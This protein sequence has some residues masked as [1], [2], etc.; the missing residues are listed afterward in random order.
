MLIDLQLPGG[1][2]L[3]RAP[4][5]NLKQRCLSVICTGERFL[6]FGAA[7]LPLTSRS[8]KVD[9]EKAEKLAKNVASIAPSR[10]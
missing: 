6:V 1:H 9:F 5:A 7:T 8:N 10:D 3:F 2:N 4:Y